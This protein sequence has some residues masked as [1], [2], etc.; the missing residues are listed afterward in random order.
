LATC[1][2]EILSFQISAVAFLYCRNK[3][4]SIHCYRCDNAQ[5]LRSRVSRA[6]P[7]VLS[8]RLYLLWL[9]T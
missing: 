2:I 1:A 7:H 4:V 8:I 5:L 3:G 6:M 9:S